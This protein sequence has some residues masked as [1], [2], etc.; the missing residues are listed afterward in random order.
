MGLVPLE[1]DPDSGLW[2]FWVVETGE[3]PVR[4]PET[5]RW[6][7]SA[8]TGIVL[9]LLPG[10]TFSMGST[11]DPKGPNYDPQARI[12]ETP[13]EVTLAPFFLSK[14]E[15]TQGQWQRM[16]NTTPSQWGADHSF[17]GEDWAEHPVERVDWHQCSEAL[18]Q[19]GLVLPTEAQWEY[20]ARGGTDTPWWSG[21]DEGT[22]EGAGNL[23]DQSRNRGFAQKVEVHD[24]DDGFV[25]HAPV[26]SF[27]ANP[28][29]LFDT[30]GNVWEWC[31]DPFVEDPPAAREG[32]GLR[33]DEVQEATRVRIYRGGSFNDTSILAR[34][35][36]RGPRT[37]EY[38]NDN[39]GVRPARVI[40]P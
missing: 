19:R 16:M 4:D 22:L 32:D 36:D 1:E 5:D 10:V 12:E 3:R 13:M 40:D 31:E 35:A 17:G 18:R 25:A 9:V 11:T 34:S 26:G 29:G 39:L 38:R 21:S 20:G 14:Y 23:A 27:V 7:I 2:E 30:M 15:L 6:I 24:W 28:Y 8:E 37:P 33:A